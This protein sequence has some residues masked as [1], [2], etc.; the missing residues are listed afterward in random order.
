MVS[1]NSLV[2]NKSDSRFVVVRFITRLITD[3]HYRPNR[4]PLNPI[5]IINFATA[6]VVCIAAMLF[7][8]CGVYN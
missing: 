8:L 2:I 5:T 4:T 3:R 1:S 6:Y 7:T